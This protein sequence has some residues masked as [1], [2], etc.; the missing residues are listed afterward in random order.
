MEH[1]K[2]SD[3]GEGSGWGSEDSDLD[4]PDDLDVGPDAVGDGSYVPPT[5]GT[6]QA[7][8]WTNNSQLAG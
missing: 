3:G 5:M 1:L 7:H 8:Y 2:A 6:S 4:L